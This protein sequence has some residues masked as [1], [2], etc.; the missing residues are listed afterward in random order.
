MSGEVV[1]KMTDVR[2]PMGMRDQPTPL[3]ESHGHKEGWERALHK[4]NKEL[5]TA[6]QKLTKLLPSV[7]SEP[8]CA[9]PSLPSPPPP[10]PLQDQEVSL[11]AHA[12]YANALT[13]RRRGLS[14]EIL[15]SW[16]YSGIVR[17]LPPEKSLVAARS[18]ATTTHVSLLPSGGTNSLNI[19]NVI[20]QNP[21]IT[22]P[23][24]PLLIVLVKDVIWCIYKNYHVFLEISLVPEVIYAISCIQLVSYLMPIVKTSRAGE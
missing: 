1:Q 15:S 23:L 24:H 16:S 2:G 10:P 14:G 3:Q 18:M 13:G 5:Q 7:N 17:C 12:A 19:S 9:T 20:R 8:V 11:P 6:P 21:M 22:L 4:R